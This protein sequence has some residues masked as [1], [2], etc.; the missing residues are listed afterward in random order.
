MIFPRLIK[1]S[2][3]HSFFLFG[4]RATGK[5]FYLSRQWAKGKKEGDLFW[6]DLLRPEVEREYQLRPSTLEKQIEALP[7]KT[8]IHSY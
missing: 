7:K 8:K 2:K 5:S 3:G 6:V 4:A 1:C